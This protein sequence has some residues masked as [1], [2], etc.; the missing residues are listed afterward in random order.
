MSREFLLGAIII[1]SL[2]TYICYM[3]KIPEGATQGH[4]L[5]SKFFRLITEENE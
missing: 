1:V 2:F 3:I 5:V 4:G